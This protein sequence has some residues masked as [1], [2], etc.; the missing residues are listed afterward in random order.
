MAVHPEY[1]SLFDA[2]A[3]KDIR[4]C[5]LRDELDSGEILSDLDLLVEEQRF[6]EVIDTLRS[7]GYHL[8]TTH[9]MLPFK[10]VLVKFWNGRFIVIDLHCRIVQEDIVMLD[11]E[12]VLQN[13]V[14]GNGYSLPATEDLI[15]VLVL[16]NILGKNRIQSK[17]VPVIRN[18]LEQTDSDKLRKRLADLCP[19][20]VADSILTV[21][22]DLEAYQQPSDRLSAVIVQLTEHY[23]GAD[24]GLRWR[25][26]R[27]RV[28]NFRK[29]WNLLPRAPLYAL[30]G[31]D[32]VGKSS[33]N[34]ALLSAL[35]QPGGFPAV[36]EYM[37][38]WGHY[39]LKW[40]K[41]ELFSPGW[42][43]TTGE[44]LRDMFARREHNGPGL[45]VTIGIIGKMIRGQALTEQEQQQHSL[46]RFQSRIF[47][48]LRYL[49]SLYA[50]SRFMLMITL[51]MYYRYYIVWRYRRRGTTVITDRYIYDLMTGRMH[52]YIPNYR[53][54]R[55]FLC[56]IFPRPTKVF[57]LHNDPETILRRK[58]DLSADVL[59]QFMSLYEDQAEKRGFKRVK[60]NRPPDVLAAEIITAQIHEIVS[61]ARR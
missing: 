7:L 61:R 40:T 36:T 29:R 16:H 45:R 8:K 27:R 10:S 56:W 30:T 9:R 54:T 32:G 14:F 6:S 48:T 2:L 37:G 38:P 12:Q 19:T 53:R 5:L 4:C 39:R 59:R 35:N 1:E 33:L 46:I 22:G 18:L 34:D 60:T 43:L 42:S 31:V 58:D 50:A 47:L 55:M 11:S 13:C 52:D 44:W 26:I 20:E 3:A 23:V 28:R 21:S 15:A 51:E 25:R 57:L 41:G 17:H 24:P 49:R